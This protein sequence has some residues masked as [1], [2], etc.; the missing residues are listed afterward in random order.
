M[1]GKNYVRIELRGSRRDVK[2][3]GFRPDVKNSA[4]FVYGLLSLAIV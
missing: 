3:K 4:M 2:N 1:Y